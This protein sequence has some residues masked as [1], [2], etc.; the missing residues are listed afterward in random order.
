[1]IQAFPPPDQLPAI[2]NEPELLKKVVRTFE[3]RSMEA[4]ILVNVE[5]SCQ[6]ATEELVAIQSAVA[7]GLPLDS[8]KLS[9]C[10]FARLR[11]NGITFHSLAW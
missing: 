6:L 1:M 9:V 8:D 4:K 3:P 7:E 10:R 11:V 5:E 2:P